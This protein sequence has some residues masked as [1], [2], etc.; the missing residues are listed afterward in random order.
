MAVYTQNLKKILMTIALFEASEP[1]SSLYLFIY[2]FIFM[3]QAFLPL[4]VQFA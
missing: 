3:K 1:L 2:L 4:P